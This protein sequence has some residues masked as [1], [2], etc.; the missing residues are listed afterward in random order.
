MNYSNVVSVKVV[1]VKNQ[2]NRFLSN[3]ASLE[4][5][6]NFGIAPQ[7]QENAQG[8]LDEVNNNISATEQALTLAKQ[9]MR[10]LESATAALEVV[11]NP[12]CRRVKLHPDFTPA[13]AATLGLDSPSTAPKTLDLH[14]ATPSL[15]AVDK[16]EGKIEVRFTRY[17][18]NG[19]ALYSK[20]ADDT[21]WALV[22]RATISPFLDIR[23]ML[24]PL[25]PELRR[26]CAVYVRKDQ[27][28]GNFSDEVE[29]ACA[30]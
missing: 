5:P 11:I 29:I 3:L 17:N 15:T 18:S 23:P 22:G 16:G 13:V 8:L 10:S 7:E 28:I 2:A 26:Y 21:D 4:N 6:S 9:K 30:P 25:K 19:I 12:M 27:E 24:E 14:N 1:S 20:R